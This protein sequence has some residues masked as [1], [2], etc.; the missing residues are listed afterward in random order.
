MRNKIRASVCVHACVRAF[1][2]QWLVYVPTH[3][4]VRM[5]V[6]ACVRKCICACVRKCVR[7]CVSACV[8]ASLRACVRACVRAGVRACVSVCARA[9]EGVEGNHANDLTAR[10][11][12]DSAVT[13]R[14]LRWRIQ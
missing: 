10:S 3:P 7:A 11:R 13:M 5:H 12:Y 2:R 8:R 14:V 6:C 9:R 1:V 4:H